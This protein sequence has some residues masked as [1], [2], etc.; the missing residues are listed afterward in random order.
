MIKNRATKSQESVFATQFLSALLLVCATCSTSMLPSFAHANPSLN[1]PTPART[2]V[3]KG[4]T[5]SEDAATAGKAHAEVDAQ[6]LHVASNDGRHALHFT[7]FLQLAYHQQLSERDDGMDSGVRIEHFR[8]IVTGQYN[9]IID[10]MFILQIT[11]DSV[12]LLYGFVTLHPHERIQIRAGLQ[13]PIFAIEMRQFQQAMLFI[14]RS[15]DSSIGVIC[16]LGLALDFRVHDQL[17]LEIGVYNGTDDHNVYSGIQEKSLS[18]EIGARWYAIG[19]DAPSAETPGFLTFGSAAVLRRNEASSSSPHLTAHISPGE[20][21]FMEYGDDVYA[22]GLT[23]AT[24]AFAHAGYKGLYAEGKFTT[25]SQ[26]VQHPGGAGRVVKHAWLAS[27]AYT[28]GGQ[29]GWTGTTVDRGLFEGGLG[30]LQFKIRG[31]GLR[32]QARGDDFFEIDGAAANTLAAKGLSAG[33]SWF[34]SDG[35]RVQADYNWTRFSADHNNLAHQKEH[36]LSLGITA[37]Y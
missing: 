31:H 26:E 23:L 6:G 7:P 25:S 32:A 9:E 2:P 21:T 28:V 13:N 35:L 24:T 1:V 4:S 30:A 14:N 10:Y 15:M 37:G 19:K 12:G 34:L 16:D 3:G 18:G 17:Q 27:L 22:D 5:S 36:L 20:H 11:A 29:S 8:P 33:V